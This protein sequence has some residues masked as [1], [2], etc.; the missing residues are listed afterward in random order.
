MNQS[1]RLITIEEF[2]DRA[3]KV[4]YKF[5]KGDPKNRLRYLTKTGILPHA[6]RLQA[7]ETDA[8]TSGYYPETALQLLLSAQKLKRQE[9]LSAQKIADR[10]E[11]IKELIEEN[12]LPKEAERGAL[13]ESLVTTLRPER[14]RSAS[15]FFLPA[16]A[17]AAVFLI[18]LSQTVFGKALGEKMVGGLRASLFPGEA[19]RQ[20]VAET[21]LK[22]EGRGPKAEGEVL[23]EEAPI[24]GYRLAV[25]GSPNLLKNSSFE[26][27]GS[28]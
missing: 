8:H 16:L 11:S 19:L 22:A 6:I 23:A 18:V 24:G 12:K 27:A 28:T 10:V 20:M 15:R 4:G 21:G 9:K 1:A 13:P 2:I 25:I 5:G 3:K 26:S 7:K 17:G 14:L